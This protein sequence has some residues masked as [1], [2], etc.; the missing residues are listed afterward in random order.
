MG[1]GL[2][3]ELDLGSVPVDGPPPDSA[4]LYS[5]SAGRFIVTVD[6]EKKTPLRSIFRV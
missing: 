5:E 6:P 1:G 4:I 2:G 3:M